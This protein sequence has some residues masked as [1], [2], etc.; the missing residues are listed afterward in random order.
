MI[1]LLFGEKNVFAIEIEV[2]D[3]DRKKGRIRFWIEG[4]PMG[5]FKR[6]HTFSYFLK[7]MKK[8]LDEVF[9]RMRKC[10]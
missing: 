1:D 10:R 6:Q 2:A 4:K 5:T 7:A 8:M 9:F 3:V